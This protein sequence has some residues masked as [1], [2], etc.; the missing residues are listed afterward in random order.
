MRRLSAALVALTAA[1]ALSALSAP[2][3]AT[4]KSKPKSEPKEKPLVVS[5]KDDV[6]SGQLVKVSGGGCRG[7]TVLIFFIDGKEFHRGAT[8]SGDWSY[9]IKLPSGLRS[10]SHDLS[11]QCKGGK[12]KPARFHVSKKG[13]GSFNVW[14]DKVI[15]GDKVHADGNG[16]KGDSPVYITLDGHVIKRTFA[17][18]HGNFDKKVRIPEHIRKGRHVVSAFCGKRHLGSD[19]IKVKPIYKQ[20]PDKV[21]TDKNVV[22]PG[23]KMKVRG[24]DCKYGEPVAYLDDRPIALTVSSRGKG[25]AGEVTVPRGTTPGKHKFYAG[26]EDGSDGYTDLD[27]LDD[28]EYEDSSARQA[29]GSQTPSDAAMWAGLFAGIALLVASTVITTRRRRNH[30]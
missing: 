29:F 26:C 15:G 13:K 1:I 14:P 3:W 19:G 12:H 9:Q 11:A 20:T 22:K 2:A 28:D 4:P 7:I 10:G 5:P 27:V 21:Y 24:D 16:C 25:F 23:K 8:K 17:D 18:E 6:R 30:G